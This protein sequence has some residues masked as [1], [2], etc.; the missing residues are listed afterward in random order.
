MKHFLLIAFLLLCPLSLGA[1]AYDV[2]LGIT[3]ADVFF[4]TDAP[5]V[6]GDHIRLYARVH[7]HGEVDVE[8]YVA[9]FQGSIP[10]EESQIISVRAGG[11]PEEVF[12]DFVVPS[13]TFNIRADIKGTDPQDQNSSNDSAMTKLLSPIFDDDRDGVANG[14]DNCPSQA[15]PNQADADNDSLGDVC[16]DDDDNDG[17]SDDVESEIGSSPTATDTDSDGVTDTADAYPNDPA[18]TSVPTSLEELFADFVE[19]LDS[20]LMGTASTDLIAQAAADDGLEDLSASLVFSPKAIFSYSRSAWNKFSF[21]A[22]TPELTGYRF[23][24]DFADGVSSNRPSPEHEYQSYGDFDVSLR[25][26]GPDG[27]VSE[28]TTTV[29]VPFFT[30]HNSYVLMIVGLLSLLLLFGLVFTARMSF[31]PKRQAVE[32]VTTPLVEESDP[33]PASQPSPSEAAMVNEDP[34]EPEVEEPELEEEIP[35]APP[36]KRAPVKQIAIRDGDLED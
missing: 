19:D 23:E 34:Q 26:T 2:D 15:N 6:A 35:A 30:L 10:I 13:G 16:D 36:A 27:T 24:W 9:F 17:I 31:I 12:V 20:G 32:L 1:A 25:I 3:A 7:N 33:E 14:D 29:S 18:Q 4:D 28:D 22:L 5:L 21:K 8:G 11:A